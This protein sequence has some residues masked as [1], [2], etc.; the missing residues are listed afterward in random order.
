MELLLLPGTLALKICSVDLMHN[1][2]Q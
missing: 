2:S 1:F